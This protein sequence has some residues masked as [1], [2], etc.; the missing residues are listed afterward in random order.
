M[1]TGLQIKA[2]RALLRLSAAELAKQS[3]VS[4]STI[5][6]LERFDGIPPANMS[7][8]MPLHEVF[9]K[10]GIEFLGT[11]DEDPGVRLKTK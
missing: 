1:I 9:T 8:I 10:A 6:R 5:Q 11:P 7:S 2:A 4:L 3:G